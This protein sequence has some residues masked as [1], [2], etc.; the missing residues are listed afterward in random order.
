MP[1]LHILFTPDPIH[2]P[3][4]CVAALYCTMHH[5]LV[6][7]WSLPIQMDRS[8]A[9]PNGPFRW[10]HWGVWAGSGRIERVSKLHPTH[11]M[12]TGGVLVL[13]LTRDIINGLN[14]WNSVQS[15]GP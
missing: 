14:H 2:D 12:G 3:L 10:S 5:T 6:S 1:N 15:F 8:G 13:G 9:H 11:W 7:I 4:C